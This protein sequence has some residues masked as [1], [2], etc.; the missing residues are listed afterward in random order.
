MSF[1]DN[2]AICSVWHNI[3]V[4][5]LDIPVNEVLCVVALVPLNLVL[6]GAEVARVV[7]ASRLV[8]DVLFIFLSE[9]DVFLPGVDVDRKLLLSTIYNLDIDKV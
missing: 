1:V 4:L 3:G 2:G 8:L 6:Y 5:L 7:I 9:T